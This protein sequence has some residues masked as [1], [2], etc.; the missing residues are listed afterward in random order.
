MMIKLTVTQDTTAKKSTEDSSELP[1]D[2]THFVPKGKNYF[3][4]EIEDAP[5]NHWFT[6]LAY[7]AGEWYFF[8]DHVE[9][10]KDDLT[11]SQDGIDLIKKFEGLELESYQDSVGVWTVGYGHTETAR[12]NMSI[13]EKEAEGLLREDLDHFEEGV[14]RLVTVSIS[15]N[16]FDALVSFSFNVGLGAFSES[17]LLQ[18]INSNNLDQAE[19]EFSRWVYAGGN[20]LE[21]LIN[22]RKAEAKLFGSDIDNKEKEKHKKTVDARDGFTVEKVNWK[23]FGS[24]VSKYFIIG[25][26]FQWDKNRI[27]DDKDIQNNILELAKEL[28]KIREEWGSPIQVTSWYR[29]SDINR[30]VGG[31]PN[32]QHLTGGAVDVYPSNGNIW[33]FQ[34][35]LD[36][37]MWRDRALGYGAIKG[38]VHLDL[39]QK[40]IRWD[41]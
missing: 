6:K 8:K 23:A 31:V 30:A 34:E 33:E 3:A 32:S 22:R 36:T 40:A 27:T 19:K 37:E 13:S 18:E 9:V 1:E 11:I 4:E 28:D 7:G 26:V 12:P 39:R 2:K 17:T 24:P 41:Y 20:K 5:N 38:F 14:N 21:G 29:P 25:E 35:W 16:Q 15:Q 10:E